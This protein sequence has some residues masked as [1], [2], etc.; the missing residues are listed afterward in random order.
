VRKD[1]VTGSVKKMLRWAGFL[2]VGP[3]SVGSEWAWALRLGFWLKKKST[4][5]PSIIAKIR[6]P[7]L[8]CKTEYRD[9]PNYA[10]R[11]VYLP[12]LFYEWFE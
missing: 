8:N 6:F 5:H 12:R 3:P 4:F 10:N 7:S 9:S 1:R 11:L 2:E